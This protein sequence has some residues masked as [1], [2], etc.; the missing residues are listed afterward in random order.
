MSGPRLS[1]A[2][3]DAIAAAWCAGRSGASIAREFGVDPSYPT[4]L[5]RRRGLT[6]QPL[7][8]EAVRSPSLRWVLSRARRR[9]VEGR[10]TER[11]RSGGKRDKAAAERRQATIRQALEGLDDAAKACFRRCREAHMSIAESLAL[12]RDDQAIRR[13]AV[14]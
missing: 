8:R 2:A 13:S 14:R 10:A 12:A 6:R 5:A 7:P 3:K 4:I 1:D 9:T 11:A